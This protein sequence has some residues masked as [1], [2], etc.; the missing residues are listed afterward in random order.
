[1]KHE[2]TIRRIIATMHESWMTES[3]K[4]AFED[5]LLAIFGE[6][7]GSDIEKGI[8]A[9]HSPEQQEAMGVALL[10]SIT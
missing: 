3:D 6:Q 4:L 7:L 9:G 5:D 8:Q 1:M 10:R 2:A